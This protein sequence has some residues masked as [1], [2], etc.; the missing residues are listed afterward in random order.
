MPGEVSQLQDECSLKPMFSRSS[1]TDL[2]QDKSELAF[3]AVL[4]SLREKEIAPRLLICAGHVMDNLRTQ[5]LAAMSG[6]WRANRCFCES[7]S[8]RQERPQ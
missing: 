7:N 4:P 6:E 3:H 2:H 1:K 8:G 5:P